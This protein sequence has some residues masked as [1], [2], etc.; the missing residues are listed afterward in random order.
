[1]KIFKK[2]IYK[3][4]PDCD[5]NRLY[6]IARANNA[7][8]DSGEETTITLGH[9]SEEDPEL[10]TIPVGT[11]CN[12]CVEGE[13]LYVDFDIDEEWYN[14]IKKYNKVSVELWVD[15]IITPI[16][17]LARN[18]PALEVGLVKYQMPDRDCEHKPYMYDEDNDMSID[19]I[20][21]LFAELLEH[22]E[23][24]A[25]QTATDELLVSL[26]EQVKKHSDTMS[27]LLEPD[28]LE[29]ETGE[30]EQQLD[31]EG[32][33]IQKA[34][35]EEEG[36]V[37]DGATEASPEQIGFEQEKNEHPEMDDEQIKQLVADHLAEDPNY[38]SPKEEE[39]VEEVKEEVAEGETPEVE[40]EVEKNDMGSSAVAASA[41][42]TYV[43]DLKAKKK[44]QEA[45][46]LVQSYQNKLLKSE[47]EKAELVVKYQYET[48]K[49][50]L[51]ELSHTYNFDPKEEIELVSKLDDAQ[52]DNHKKIIVTRYQKSPAGRSVNP[53]HNIE[54]KEVNKVDKVN[55]AIKLAQT[56][57]IDFKEALK[58]V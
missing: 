48:R 15:N 30:V 52:W 27:P 36:E 32:N 55:K 7:R 24:K 19:E 22:S 45:M 13:D 40:P 23:L 17:L 18:R 20:K 9:T 49:N 41:N 14:Q 58:R 56:E 51:L 4:N 26:Q 37:M 38:Y 12:F 6:E 46:D 35:G 50:Q 47:E 16:A 39:A 28:E 3:V 57:G 34:P 10:I 11:A 53:I 54:D 31:E 8:I 43:P 25:K 42:N 2:K 29:G 21:Q 5:L 33:P 1:M 44:Y